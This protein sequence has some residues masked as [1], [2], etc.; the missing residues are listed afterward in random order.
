MH[1]ILLFAYGTLLDEEVQRRVFGRAVAMQPARLA[2]WRVTPRS[3]AGRFPGIVR[4]GGARTAGALLRLSSSD[5][6]MADAYEEAPRLYRRKRVTARIG[7]RPLRCWVYVPAD[8]RV[9]S[10]RRPRLAEVR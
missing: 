5:L 7:R 1:R 6:G 3:V 10:E 9:A 4:A 8:A 2:G